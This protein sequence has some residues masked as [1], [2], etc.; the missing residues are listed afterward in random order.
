MREI[1]PNSPLSHKL[2][3]EKFLS[4]EKDG[5]LLATP[6]GVNVVDAILPTLIS[7]LNNFYTNV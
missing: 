6:K 1:F 5:N 7:D 3:E 4:W 2:F